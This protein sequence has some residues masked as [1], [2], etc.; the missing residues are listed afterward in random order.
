MILAAD[1]SI[2]SQSS[3]DLSSNPTISYQEFMAIP[4]FIVT[5]FVGAVGRTNLTC[6]ICL[7]QSWATSS[8]PAAVSPR[9]CIITTRAEWGEDGDMVV[10]VEV[11]VTEGGEKEDMEEERRRMGREVFVRS[12][13]DRSM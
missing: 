7:A 11:R 5:G 4:P 8:K 9:P 2:P 1:S 10:P 3:F 13:E 12:R 6:G